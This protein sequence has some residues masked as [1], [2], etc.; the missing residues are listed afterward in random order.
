MS[1]IRRRL[2]G[3]LRTTIVACVPWTMLGLLIGLV[4]QSGGGPDVYMV[5]GRQVPGVLALCVIAGVLVGIINGLTFS[6]LVLAAE[7]GKTVEQLR[8]WRVATWGALAAGSALGLLF[9]SVVIASI[10]GAVGAVGAL[11]AL[12]MTRRARVRSEG[13]SALSSRRLAPR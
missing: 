11:G 8:G 2:R 12:W 6:G 7:R 4:L 5:L 9:Q 10:G 1:M 13:T 3:V